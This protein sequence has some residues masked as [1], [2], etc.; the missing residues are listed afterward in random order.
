[1]PWQRAADGTWSR[2][3]PRAVLV[4]RNS[5]TCHYYRKDRS[6]TIPINQDHSGM[7]KFSRSDQNLSVIIQ[8][9]AELCS[10]S[11]GSRQTSGV[12]H[13]A[14][15]SGD[16]GGPSVGVRPVSVSSELE[17]AK[18]I[19][20]VP[21]SSVS[22]ELGRGLG[23]HST[24]VIEVPEGLEDQLQDLGHLLY[25]VQSKFMT[26]G[27]RLCFTPLTFSLLPDMY[28]RLQSPEL[29]DRADQIEAPHQRTFQWVFNLPVFSLWLQEGSEFLWIQGKPGSG[30]STLM[31]YIYQ[32]RQ[33]WDLL[34]NWRSDSL[35]IK[36]C[37][38]FHHRGSP[39]QKSLEGVLRSLIIQ[40]MEPHRR[41]FEK[42]TRWIWER[43]EGLKND[44]A[45]LERQLKIVRKELDEIRQSKKKNGA[46]GGG[47][48]PANSRAPGNSRTYAPFYLPNTED[49]IRHMDDRLN[50]GR[51]LLRRELADLGGEFNHRGTSPEAKLL[52]KLV[53]EYQKERDE[54]ILGLEKIL[55]LLLDQDV[56]NVDL[57]L[58]FDALD[59]FDGHHITISR[60]LRSLVTT[61]PTSRTRVK[62]CFSSRS[63]TWLT[64]KFSTCPS[65]AVEDYTTTD[66]EEYATSSVAGLQT[67]SPSVAQLVPAVIKR[68]NGVFLWVR[69]AINILQETIA[70][71][72]G[73]IT[74]AFLE[75]KLQGIPGDLIEFYRLIVERISH[76]NR[77]FTYALLELL[78]R[79]NGSPIRAAHVRDAVLVS[80]CATRGEAKELL[81][82]VRRREGE[83]RVPVE[84]GHES[85]L[86]ETRIRNQLTIWGGGLVE[87]KRQGDF[88][89][90]RLM[91]QTALE[92]IASPAFKKIVLGEDPFN[93]VSEN[94]HHF[95][96]KY[97]TL[98]Q[99]WASLNRQAI[100]CMMEQ[101]L[102]KGHQR[103]LLELGARYSQ[104][105]LHAAEVEVLQSL[106][107]HAEQAE[108]TTEKSMC[109][110]ILSAVVPG[111][112][113]VPRRN[114]AGQEEDLLFLATSCGL[115]RCL[116]DWVAG[117]P[118][119]I[120]EYSRRQRPSAEVPAL[121]SLFFAPPNGKFHER[122][123]DTLDLLLSNGYRHCKA[124]FGFFGRII[125]E[126][127]RNQFA[128]SERI[129]DRVLEKV[130]IKLL[131]HDSDYYQHSTNT[132]ELEVTVDLD[133]EVSRSIWATPLHVASR[134]LTTE[135]LSA[136]A[137]PNGT[138]TE[139]RTPLHWALDP[140]KDVRPRSWDTAWRFKKAL[141]LA[142]AGGKH[143]VQREVLTTAL[144]AFESE[145][146]G[147][148]PLR[149][150]L[151]RFSDSSS[152]PGWIIRT[153]G[154]GR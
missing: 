1:M 8:A 94:G 16:I 2:N 121:T 45:G 38:F 125:Q 119:Y 62:V 22:S 41:A 109:D 5:A 17:H 76:D 47:I 110:Y 126:L 103:A 32:S 80:S 151:R 143:S 120:A 69:L 96:V 21:S 148:Q 123:L 141:V 66:I 7:V 105:R 52:G 122:Y 65:F 30:K 117:R 25:S 59:E 57:V 60:F 91:H 15:E 108:I 37:F 40:I 93:F 99:D 88:D 127:W 20:R 106:A 139:G 24:E 114:L 111:G 28:D 27:Q 3:G 97:W 39:L 81:A 131:D 51:A 70:S 56:A 92:F 33:T 42:E 124:E 86:D 10:I 87:I 68:A 152:L 89:Y 35:E 14:E 55:R 140:P 113:Q 63:S 135:L 107:Y 77:R 138:D 102:Q 75:Q 49:A 9:L 72:P 78:I 145:G 129:P 149:E 53:A 64:E 23:F 134:T 13:G 116:Q 48:R 144:M 128:E 46:S 34:H 95:Y 12:E 31:K 61:S 137:N 26:P 54:E 115:T 6:I 112:T 82:A 29:N 85:I 150:A 147:T 133:S 130:A 73:T 118:N 101:M 19:P 67:A 18:P 132:V 104:S 90:P 136:G 146:Y 83:E 11:C 4:D 142:R 36:A 58:F 43:Y 50:Q 153:L 79:H 71:S 154:I 44:Q 100:A 84:S 74:P 98:E